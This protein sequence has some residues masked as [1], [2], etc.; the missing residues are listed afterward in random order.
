MKHLKILSTK[1]VY[2]ECRDNVEYQIY[3]DQ[4]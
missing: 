4:F 2:V 3:Q 1:E